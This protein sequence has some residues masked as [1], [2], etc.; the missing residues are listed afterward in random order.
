MIFKV[1]FLYLVRQFVLLYTCSKA[2][3]TA[4]L[5]AHPPNTEINL[6]SWIKIKKALLSSAFFTGVNRIVLFVANY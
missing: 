3:L 6:Y 4:N 1:C 2:G 5:Q